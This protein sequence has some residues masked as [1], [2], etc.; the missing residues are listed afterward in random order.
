LEV[1]D[2]EFVRD[3]GGTAGLSAERNGMLFVADD[4]KKKFRDARSTVDDA[5]ARHRISGNGDGGPLSTADVAT[6]L[7]QWSSNFKDFL[8]G[9]SATYYFYFVLINAGLLHSVT[10]Q[11]PEAAMHCS[12]TKKRSG[13]PVIAPGTSK[14]AN[15]SNEGLL[16]A[17]STPIV[18]EATAAQAQLEACE[19]KRAQVQLTLDE[20]KK[21][22]AVMDL[23]S[24]RRTLVSR[25]AGSGADSM[26]PFEAAVIN[27]RIEAIETLLSPDKPTVEPTPTPRPLTPTVEPPNSSDGEE[28]PNNND[29]EADF[30]NSG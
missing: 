26:D 21:G 17:M 1:L 6:Q 20:A 24:E 5:L 30:D 15:L 22:P 13:A 9:D 8:Q 3:A 23:L 4:L 14:K 28:D 19:L 11:M 7:T 25:R 27:Q 16:A 18:I 12:D 10:A 29:D 2:R